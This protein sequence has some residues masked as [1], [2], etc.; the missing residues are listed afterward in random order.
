MHEGGVCA[1]AQA[2]ITHWAQATLVRQGVPCLPGLVFRILCGAYDAMEVLLLVVVAGILSI[3][4]Q[5][6]AISLEVLGQY[7]K[8]LILRIFQ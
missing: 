8:C 7:Y 6:V 5:A 1:Q 3:I 4:R 2:C